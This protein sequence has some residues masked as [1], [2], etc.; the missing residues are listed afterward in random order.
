MK[1]TRGFQL[2]S[3]NKP[4]YPSPNK[5]LLA[6]TAGAFTGGLS[7]VYGKTGGAPPSKGLRFDEEEEKG[8]NLKSGNTPPF[9]MMGSKSFGEGKRAVGDTRYKRDEWESPTKNMKTGNYSH[10]F[11]EEPKDTP[12]YLKQFG[13]GEGTSPTLQVDWSKAPGVGTQERA[14]WYKENNLAQDETT[15]VKGG[16][17][18]ETDA[19]ETDVTKTTADNIKENIVEPPKVNKT[20]TIASKIGNTLVG[21]F[22]TGL[23]RVYG[24][25]GVIAGNELKFHDSKDKDKKTCKDA[26]GNVVGCDS[27]NAV[28]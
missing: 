3:G 7:A 15:K 25:E 10:K 16:G 22:T 24:G 21:A 5:S 17:E 14:D 23:S 2:R 18:E 6:I 9:K 19:K 12:A 8:F 13:M 4:N 26:D 28:K 11:E 1:K 20:K 27:P